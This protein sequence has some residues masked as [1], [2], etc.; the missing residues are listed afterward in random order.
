MIHDNKIV[1]SFLWMSLFK[2]YRYQ[3][4]IMIIPYSIGVVAIVYIICTMV[5][6]VRKNL[7]EK[8]YMRIIDKYSVSWLKIFR[9]IY[10]FFERKI[11]G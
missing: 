11:F 10:N 5:D 1:R 2:N 8:S 9:E 3:D 6:L 7:F 4:S